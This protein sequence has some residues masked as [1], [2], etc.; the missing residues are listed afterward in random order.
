[1]EQIITIDLTR[2]KAEE[3]FEHIQTMRKKRQDKT[4]MKGGRRTHYKKSSYD[5]TEKNEKNSSS[6]GES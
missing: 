5:T 1:M 3:N 2:I 6:K 4:L